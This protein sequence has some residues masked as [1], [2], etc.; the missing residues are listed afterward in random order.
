MHTIKKIVISSLL[1]LNAYTYSMQSPIASFNED[2]VKIERIF[3][4]YKHEL[5][6]IAEI[7]DT[8]LHCQNLMTVQFSTHTLDG[9]LRIIAA[10]EKCLLEQIDRTNQELQIYMQKL[11]ARMQANSQ[12]I[13]FD[14]HI[15][16]LRTR[17]AVLSSQVTSLKEQR[18]AMQE[19][20]ENHVQSLSDRD[21]ANASF[22]HMST[23][24]N[25][26]VIVIQQA[27]NATPPK[28]GILAGLRKI[29]SCL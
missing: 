11:S 2:L 19:A 28:K 7:T 25:Q 9:R 24:Y 10:R 3:T 12:E 8:A 17:L 16:D 22:Q 14:E 23:E 21:M 13:T 27:H 6:I 26:D 5:A 4:P 18:I 29:L 15:T 1:L 20:L